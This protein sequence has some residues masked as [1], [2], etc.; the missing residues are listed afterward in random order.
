MPW[1][2]PAASLAELSA[3]G[4]ASTVFGTLRDHYD[5]V[6]IDTT[7]LDQPQVIQEFSSF[8]AAI[9]L[10][11]LYVVQDVRVTPRQ[12]LNE[13]WLSLRQ[14]RLP[15]VAAIENFVGEH[16]AEPYVM[17]ELATNDRG[18]LALHE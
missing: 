15:L 4:R 3:S 2:G 9:Q 10:D 18:P 1:R 7:P 14:A 6:L 13:C 12:Q 17:A 5:L 8:A 11:A 16:A